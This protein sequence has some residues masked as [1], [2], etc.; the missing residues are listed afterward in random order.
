MLVAA[1]AWAALSRTAVSAAPCTIINY[2]FQPD[3]FRDAGA[4][5]CAFDPAHP[6]LGPQIAVWLTSAD[7][8]QYVDTLLVTN[9][10]AVHGIGNRPG[11]WNLASGPRFPYGARAMVLPIWAHARGRLYTSITMK[12]QPGVS[13]D[14]DELTG[15]ENYSSPE[16]YFCRPM[17]EKEEVDAITCPS[18]L[19]R[20]DKGVLDPTQPLSYYPPRADLFD[21]GGG[22]P[23]IP[24][25]NYPDSCDPGDSAQYFAMNDIDSV[26]AATPAYGTPF[27]GSW[28]VPADLAAGDYA[29]SVEVGKEFDT[30]AANSWP[31]EVTPLDMTTYAGYGLSGN[32]GQPSV[33][34]RV[35]F[36]YTPGAPATAS[37]T[38]IA[39]YADWTGATGM[40]NPPDGT[41]SGDPGSGSGRLLL[42][43]LGHGPARVTVSL[44]SCP[45]VD[46]NV[47][48]SPLPLP[49]SF[50]A[51]ASGGTAAAISLLQSS[52]SGGQPVIGYQIRYTPLGANRPIDATSFP[53]WTAAGT[54]PAG[55]PGSTSTL[56]IDGLTPL[57]TYAIGISAVGVCGSSPVTFQRFATPAVKYVQL[58]GC[59]IATAAFGSDLTPEVTSLRALRDAATARSTLARIAVDLYYRS[60]P[61]LAQALARSPVAR[62]LVRAA[63]R[64]VTR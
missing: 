34:Y 8:T 50:T 32:V 33:L 54:V 59:F 16:P 6:D 64:T 14:N 15:H 30:N 29:L 13:G 36:S 24:R 44:G 58:S 47:V 19:F 49:V 43:D 35:P 40:V 27:T 55:P 45:A 10:V 56:Q 4:S 28:V 62:A 60:S 51:S 9:A 2:T 48:P 39:G 46:C 17:L 5:G 25:I 3:C 63:I 41:I 7:G 52:E 22:T 26:A 18:G 1:G 12:G 53:A 23:C 42:T 57:T 20:S 37:V 21:F 11:T 38:D 31:T 61:P